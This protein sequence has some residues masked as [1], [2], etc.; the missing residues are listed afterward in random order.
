MNIDNLTIGQ[1]RELEEFLPVDAMDGRHL[2]VAPET[3][4][5]ILNAIPKSKA[6]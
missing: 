4:S 1:A 5:Q 6:A 3:I 2:A